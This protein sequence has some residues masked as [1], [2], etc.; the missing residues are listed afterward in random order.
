VS[1][2]SG[3]LT[4]GDRVLRQQILGPDEPPFAP[5]A[6]DDEFDGSSLDGKWTWLD[7][8]GMTAEVYGGYLKLAIIENSN[9]I[10]GIYQSAP[11]GAW[12]I[13][14]KLIQDETVTNVYLSMFA[15]DSTTGVVRGASLQ[16][17]NTGFITA[18]KY[19]T[20]SSSAGTWTGGSSTTKHR[21]YGYVELVW[22]ETTL[23]A[24]GSW[25]G[26]SWVQ[27][28]QETPATA[29]TIVGLGSGNITGAYR[30]SRIAWFRRVA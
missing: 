9:R 16:S 15:A 7:Q 6:I 3:R 4:S 29:P 27:I 18:L 28:A 1:I 19:A 24:R 13:R 26:V 22:N 20:P 21:G 14:S 10:R 5:N 23:T 2:I 8:G 30:Y 11:S 17:S 25:D 12:T